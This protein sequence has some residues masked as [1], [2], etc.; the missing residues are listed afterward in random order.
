[1]LILV[2]FLIIILIVVAINNIYYSDVK[3]KNL[4]DPL[5]VE[6]NLD[7]QDVTQNYLDKYIKQP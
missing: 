7:K 1:M 6:K 5:H 3:P 2:P 4:K